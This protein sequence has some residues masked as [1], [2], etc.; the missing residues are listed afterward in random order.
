MPEIT[1]VGTLTF[2]LIGTFAGSFPSD[3]RT[4]TLKELTSLHGG[5]GGNAAV[6]VKAMGC[7]VELI[8]GVGTDFLGTEYETRLSRLGIES[9]GLLCSTRATTT[10]VTIM[11]NGHDSRVYVHQRRDT[12]YEEEFEQWT[13]TMARISHRKVLYCTSEIPRVNLAA[14]SSPARDIA[15]FSPGHDIALYSKKMLAECLECCDILAVNAHEAKV[16]EDTLGYQASELPGKYSL[17]AAIIT[18]NVDGSECHS[19]GSSFE[20]PACPAESVVDT[21]GAGDAFIAGLLYSLSCGRSLRWA[22]GFAASLASFIVEAVGC[23]TNIPT[24]DAVVERM[25][26]EG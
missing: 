19:G 6:L 7:D 26:N 20:I 23:Q 1:V 25:R 18:K 10:Q 4:V 15:V 16:V 14:L 24:R 8:S 3:S 5:R 22:M 11:D 12:G 13:A 21:S 9:T 2:D 17:R